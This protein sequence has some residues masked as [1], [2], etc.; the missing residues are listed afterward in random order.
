M[1]TTYTMVIEQTK[2]YAKRM[3]YIE[4]TN[5]FKESDYYSL[6]YARKFLQ[7]YG[8]IKESGTPP[9]PHW[10]VIL[11]TDKDFELGDE[12]QIRV[13]GMFKR[14]DGDHKYIVV[15][16]ERDIWDFHQLTDEEKEDLKR[17]YP[18]VDEG[19]GWFDK[20][21]ALEAMIECEKAL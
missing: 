5:S 2:H 20:D 14:N 11:M 19:E 7:P 6:A 10:D 1:S 21:E 3:D 18:R 12:V 13:I 9:E 17:F 16:D 4:E 15:E 8:W